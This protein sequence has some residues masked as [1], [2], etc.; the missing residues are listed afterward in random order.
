MRRYDMSTDLPAE[1]QHGPDQHLSVEI[2]VYA[3]FSDM[4]CSFLYRLG[5]A[6]VLRCFGGAHFHS[7]PTLA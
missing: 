2:N 4:I 3:E 7:E 1:E 6:K 5:N